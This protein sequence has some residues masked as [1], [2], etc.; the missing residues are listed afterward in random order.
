MNHNQSLSQEDIL[1]AL[2]QLDQTVEVMS[3]IIR[4]LKHSLDDSLSSSNPSPNDSDQEQNA[5]AS[6][7]SANVSFDSNLH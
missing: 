6:L 7:S 5:L 2:D 1:I 3:N 4:R